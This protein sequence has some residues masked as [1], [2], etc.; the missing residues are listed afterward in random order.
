M[1]RQVIDIYGNILR[2]IIILA[3]GAGITSGGI[4]AKKHTAN[5]TLIRGLVI[6]PPLVPKR[7]FQ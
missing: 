7:Q 6:I 1:I 2:A 4:K 3:L 5:Q